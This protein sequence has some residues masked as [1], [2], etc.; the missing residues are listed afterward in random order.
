MSYDPTRCP[1]CGSTCGPIVCRFSALTHKRARE[2]QEW[3]RGADQVKRDQEKPAWLR[4]LLTGG[5]DTPVGR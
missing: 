3:N 2:I 5:R 4:N 1:Q